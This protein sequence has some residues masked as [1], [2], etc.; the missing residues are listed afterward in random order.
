MNDLNKKER[1]IFIKEAYLSGNIPFE[2]EDD[3]SL[4]SSQKLFNYP[5]KNIFISSS[6]ITGSI[7]K[8][9]INKSNSIHDGIS[10]YIILNDNLVNLKVLDENYITISKDLLNK[11]IL[12]NTKEFK[13]L[14]EFL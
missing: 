9:K 5:M 12:K 13:C 10:F 8:I 6:I 11:E 14:G 4:I 2:K 7:E 3:N 1:I